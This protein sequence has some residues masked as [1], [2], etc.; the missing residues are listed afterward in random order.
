MERQGLE[1]V[2][3]AVAGPF[4]YRDQKFGNKY[5][6]LN[7]MSFDLPGTMDLPVATDERLGYTS[8]EMVLQCHV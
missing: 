6:S 8:M 3:H 4:P 1:P 5:Q 2:N 7:S